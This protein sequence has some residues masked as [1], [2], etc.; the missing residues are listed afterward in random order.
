MNTADARANI[1]LI[2]AKVH[3]AWHYEKRKQGFHS[4][5]NCPCNDGRV[6]GPEV[7]PSFEKFCDKCHTAMYPYPDLPEHVK[8]YD[9]VTVLA[10][11]NAIDEVEEC[12]D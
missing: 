9:R 5:R 7:A 10:V 3:D 12:T 1:E 8:E 6:Y 4:P 11:L 2:A